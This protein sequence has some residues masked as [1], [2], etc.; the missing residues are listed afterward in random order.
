M[1]KVNTRLSIFLKNISCHLFYNLNRAYNIELNIIRTVFELEPSFL[2][3]NSIVL[4]KV[5]RYVE[6]I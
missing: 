4:L 6:E 1:L 2:S 5:K 3:N